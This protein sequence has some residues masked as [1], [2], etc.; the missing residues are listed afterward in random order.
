VL[1]N[2]ELAN[3]A[4]DWNRLPEMARLTSPAVQIAPPVPRDPLPVVLLA[5]T[6]L[7]LG[8]NLDQMSCSA[9]SSGSKGIFEV[10]YFAVWFRG[11]P[12]A[13]E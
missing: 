10:V 5:G 9:R 8:S 12:M 6:D 13:G 11:R 4:L 7:G 2:S 3:A 1:P